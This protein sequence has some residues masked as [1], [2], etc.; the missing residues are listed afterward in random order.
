MLHN[1]HVN[2]NINNNAFI[3]HFIAITSVDRCDVIC[4]ALA[5]RT[6]DLAGKIC[7][8]LCSIVGSI[9]FENSIKQ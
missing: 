2:S 3:M 5:H 7:N 1:L 6:N 4:G 8:I 9:M